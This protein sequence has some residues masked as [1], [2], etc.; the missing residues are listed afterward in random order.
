MDTPVN[1]P[2]HQIKK[3]MTNIPNEELFIRSPTPMMK[4]WIKDA[5]AF[6]IPFQMQKG[7]I[8]LTAFGLRANCQTEDAEDWID[9]TRKMSTKIRKTS[10]HIRVDDG[11]DFH[12]NNFSPL[13][14]ELAERFMGDDFSPRQVSSASGTFAVWSRE[15]GPDQLPKCLST[16]I[17]K[18]AD[19]DAVMTSLCEQIGKDIHMNLEGAYLAG[20]LYFDSC[21]P[22]DMRTTLEISSLVSSLLPP[23]FLWF[24]H[25]LNF[26]PED[27]AKGNPMQKV[28]DCF[29]A[30]IAPQAP[31]LYRVVTYANDQLH[32][33]G[34]GVRRQEVWDA[35]PLQFAAIVAH[36]RCFFPSDTLEEQEALAELKESIEKQDFPSPPVCSD[37]KSAV[38]TIA[39]H[40]VER[41]GYHLDDMTGSIPA[42]NWTRRACILITCVAFSIL[43][44]DW[45]NFEP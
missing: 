22:I 20:F 43:K 4:A 6:G 9:F 40:V 25:M 45:N 2:P 27:A 17:R 12:D 13:L 34:P 15:E 37:R 23:K 32:Y 26:T 19:R 28:L 16:G 35:T 5:D 8:F 18:L 10:P 44:P 38:G 42:D 14:T 24:G 1:V 7:L 21:Y 41:W 39:N 33:K 3:A 31:R 11:G 29:L 36:Q 30:D